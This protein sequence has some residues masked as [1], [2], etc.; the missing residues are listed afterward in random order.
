[1][2]I[3]VA[4]LNIDGQLV[5]VILSDNEMVD[6]KIALRELNAKQ[7]KKAPPPSDNLFHSNHIPTF[8]SNV[9]NNAFEPVINSPHLSNSL[10]FK[11]DITIQSEVKNFITPKRYKTKV[12]RFCPSSIR[13]TLFSYDR[14]IL[15]FSLDNKNLEGERLKA[16]IAWINRRFKHCLVLFGDSIYK[17]TLQIKNNVDETQAL[18]KAIL[19]GQ[20]IFVENKPLF[21]DNAN[22]CQFEYIFAQ[23]AQQ[24]SDYDTYN[25][26]LW[27]LFNENV[28]FN[29]GVRE[30]AT[31]FVTRCHAHSDKNMQLASTYLIEELAIFSCLA[32]KNWPVVVYPGTISIIEEI[33]N[34]QYDALPKELT[35]QIYVSLYI[36]S[37]GIV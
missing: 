16:V 13:E 29:K 21:E 2:K 33:A 34:G 35:N 1:M 17:H 25:N 20:R 22:A 7:I 11:Q 23:Q 5:R 30:F 6:A 14:C 12:L 4:F 9:L 18:E 3:K 8:I 19:L 37:R 10:L 31:Y 28:D 32:A 26:N 36:K 24:F 15:G 27:T